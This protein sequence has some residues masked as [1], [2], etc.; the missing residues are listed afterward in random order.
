MAEQRTLYVHGMHCAACEM[1]IEDK[2]AAIEGVS[3]VKA[4]LDK[5]T[6]ECS[7]ALDVDDE[8][9]AQL[10]TPHVEGYGYAIATHPEKKGVEWKEFYAALPIA[11]IVVIAFFALQKAG[12]VNLVQADSVTLPVAFLIGIVASLST[13]MAVVGGLVLSMSANYGKQAAGNIPHFSFHLGRLIG[14][15]V[16]GGLIGLLGSAFVLTPTI[17][18]VLS[19]AI[20]IVMILMGI[21]LLDIWP[22]S[23]SWQLRMPRFFS[24]AAL[25]SKFSGRYAPFVIGAATFFLPCGCTQSM[26]VYSLS[27]GSP[28]AGALT[29]LAF[30]LGTLPVLALLSF[31]TGNVAQGKHR[32]IF[33]KAAGTIVILFSLLNF[34]GGLVA[35][36][37]L[38]PV[39]S[40]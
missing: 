12:V 38:P 2:L 17:S 9:L 30:A 20:G 32:G 10:L 33:F 31:G 16:L 26:Q 34:Y 29:M 18:F 3:G 27:T 4:H 40:F 8:H 13:C 23:A 22:S 5:R 19:L 6:V 25:Q 35:I 15:F 28:L 37:L 1:L 24:T 36:G 21:N 7:C 39:F 11:L 14:F